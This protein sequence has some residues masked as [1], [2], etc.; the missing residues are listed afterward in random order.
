MIMMMIM[1]T[2]MIITMSVCVDMFIIILGINSDPLNRKA[3]HDQSS[4]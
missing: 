3:K 4:L 1:M 2:M